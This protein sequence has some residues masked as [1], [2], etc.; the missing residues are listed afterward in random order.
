LLQG[1]YWVGFF[2]RQGGPGDRDLADQRESN[3]ALAQNP[4]ELW[5][6]LILAAKLDGDLASIRQSL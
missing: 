3:A 2:K 1:R 6:E 5:R 4:Q